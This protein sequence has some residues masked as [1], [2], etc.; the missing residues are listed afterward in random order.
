LLVGKQRK[1][2]LHGLDIHM[3]KEINN[4]SAQATRGDVLVIV[5]GAYRAS[6]A[7]FI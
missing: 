3:I 1:E 6:M 7:G 4:Y 2:D 5:S